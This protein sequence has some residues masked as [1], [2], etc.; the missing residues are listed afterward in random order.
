MV[1]TTGGVYH[2][3]K[4][5]RYVVTC[6]DG[7]IAYFFSSKLYMRKFLE[8]YENNRNT[9]NARIHK[10]L[11]FETLGMDF[12]IDVCYYKEVEKRG[13]RVLYKGD[14][15]EWHEI[16][17]TNLHLMRRRYIPNYREVLRTKLRE[18]KKIT[19]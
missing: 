15:L 13:F 17:S 8:N 11:P 12:L 5:S 10:M 16:T 1:V 19:V 3:L 7:M 18:W 4:E 14:E 6:Q 9:K 2:N